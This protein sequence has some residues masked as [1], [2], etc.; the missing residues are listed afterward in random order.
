MGQEYEDRIQPSLAGLGGSNVHFPAINRWAIYDS[1]LR[2]HANAEEF[3][4]A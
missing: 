2:G 1:P 3:Y 4:D